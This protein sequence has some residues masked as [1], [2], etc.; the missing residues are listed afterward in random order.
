MTR[1]LRFPLILCG[2][3]S[4]AGSALQIHAAEPGRASAGLPPA[5]RLDGAR[6]GRTFE[7]IGVLSAG[8]AS[9]LLIDYPEPA[10]SQILDLLFKPKYGAA[11]D[12]LKVEVGG[13]V[14][15]TMG[16]EP[17]HM[18]T[19]DDENYR[20]GYEWWLMQEAKRRN[21]SI[22]L[23]CLEWGVPG[24]IG[25]G[26]FYSQDNADYLVKFLRGAKS[27]YGLDVDY[28]GIWNETPY[29]TAWIKLLRKTLDR[30]GLKAV[31]IVAADEVNAWTI[32]E[33]MKADP[34]LAAA[35]QVVG[36]HYPQYAST[37]AAQGCGKPLWS[38]EDGFGGKSGW[39]G[40]ATV[41]KICN[42]NYI[43]GKMTKTVLW[44]LITSYYDN[45]PWP[46]CGLIKA[47]TPWSGHYEVQ[48]NLWAAAHTTQFAQPGWKYLDG[49]ACGDL[50][51]GGSYVTLKST[52]GTD[53][54]VILET[55]DAKQSQPITVELSG[56]LSAGEVH[57]WRTNRQE[58]FAHL[59]TVRPAGGKL[60][61][62]LDPEAIYTLSTTTGQQKGTPPVPPPRPFP[63]PYRE[64][65]E[66]YAP[67]SMPKYFSDQGG[68]F[69]VVRRADGKGRSL[70]QVMPQEGIRW[71]YHANP[72]PETFF[73]DATWRDY[74]VLADV[75]IEEAGAVCLFGRVAAVKQDQRLPC[76]YWLKIDQT[77]KWELANDKAR[78]ATGQAAFSAG[79][80]HTLKLVMA[81]D[82]IL[83]ALDESPL[84]KVTDTTYHAG[85]VGL[86]S[87]WN[88][89]QFDHIAVVP[90]G[91]AAADVPAK[92][93]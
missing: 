33:R 7:G 10:R 25:G 60:A 45:L 59:K 6:E 92:G 50:P 32:V 58:Q 34:E 44:A 69:E 72:Q 46:D 56:G 53:Y 30:K 87:G 81:G 52:N 64:D 35:I 2:V 70:R 65:F 80:W 71:H 41:A 78:L 23:D 20:R 62:T 48:P 84:A 67:G 39:A 14:N 57:V 8:A 40:A 47:N 29:D 51:G 86:G 54:S 27:V 26:E 61:I 73:G 74:T 93:N 66:A 17:S 21:P 18:H 3:L 5:I 88:H 82:T 31:K 76:G 68:C 36:V 15:S 49:Q 19:R 89:A 38:T 85:M 16:C 11:L 37:A 55:I 24:W 9:R 90:A 79:T 83:A 4:I 12:H 77:G 13:D 63:M 91:L 22:M 75:F 43:R 28:L 42:R 1:S